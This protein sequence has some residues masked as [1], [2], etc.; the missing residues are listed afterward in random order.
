MNRIFVII[1]IIVS[2]AACSDRVQTT[3]ETEIKQH[4]NEVVLTAE[5]AKNAGLVVG[6]AENK[7]I[8]TVIKMAGKIDVPPQNIVSVSVPMGGY[9][10]NTRLLP[11]MQVRKGEVIAVIEDQQYIQL[12]QDYLTAKANITYSQ[13]EFK[14][15]S[16]L[17]ES[18]ATSDKAFEQARANYQTHTIQMR[19]LEQKLR[20]I[21]IEPNNLTPSNISRSIRLYA[22]ISGFVSAVNF[23]IGK[24]VNPTDVLF[25]L[26]DPNDIHLAL[27]VFEKD[28]SRL[29]QGQRIVAYTNS[30]PN[31]KYRGS[32]ILISRNL[33]TDNAGQVHCHI[34]NYD[35]KLVPGVFM[36]VEV[37]LTDAQVSAVPE[38]AIVSFEGKQYIFIATG[39][40]H[41]LMQEAETGT[42][43]NGYTELKNAEKL[44]GKTLV[45]KGAYTVLSALKNSGEE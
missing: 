41:F 22:P 12:Q 28:M 20:L 21:G 8:S 34:E 18:K 32:I 13:S 42:T 10:R 3:T 38:E 36:N 9:L 1:T 6:T 14:R 11:G 7:T 35:S 15:Q 25:E 23:N 37:E 19:S 39:N 5:Q 2:L 43:E 4:P 30:D 27:T 17:N 24:Y 31:K 40:N 26:I 16:E 33:S 44:N 45:L 29:K